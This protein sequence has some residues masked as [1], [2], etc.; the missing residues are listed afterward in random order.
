MSQE[1]TNGEVWEAGVG[2]SRSLGGGG[3]AV[4]VNNNFSKFLVRESGGRIARE[5]KGVWTRFQ[6]IEL[7]P[8][9]NRT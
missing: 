3:G 9:N 7:N 6:K 8:L 1:I 4:V 2:S 5:R